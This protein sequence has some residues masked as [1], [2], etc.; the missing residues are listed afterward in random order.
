M[1]FPIFKAEDY[2][3][4]SLKGEVSFCYQVKT[5][6]LTQMDE[7]ESDHFYFQLENSLKALKENYFYRFFYLTGIFYLNTN[8][9]EVAFLDCELIQM[10]NP[11]NIL[12]GD[13]DIYQDITF[14]EDYFLLNSEFIRLLNLY[15]LP[16]IGHEN[17]FT[18]FGDYVLH[19][20]KIEPL[21]AK[22]T[23]NFRRKLHFSS[24]HE[25]LRNIES[26]NAYAQSEGLYQNIING[27]DA[28]FDGEGWII[29]RATTK[30]E[31][32]LKTKSLVNKAKLMDMRLLAE[33]DGM[34]FFFNSL[35]MGVK[36]TFKRKHPIPASTLKAFVP[37]KDERLM[38]EG[39]RLGSPSGSELNFSLFHP[40][41]TNFNLLLTGTSGQGKSMLAN[42]ILLEELRHERKI[43]VLDLGNSFKKNIAY[44]GG[45]H[46]SDKF[47][48]LQFKNPAYLK[49][50]IKSVVNDN[51]LS[52]RDEG[53]LFE[54]LK[55]NQFKSMKE[56]IEFLEVHFEGIR[57]YFSELMDF[58]TDETNEFHNLTYCDLSLYSERIKAPLIIYL[59]EY[60]KNLEGKKIF[61]FDECWGLLEGHADYIAE[62]FRT[63]RKHDASAIA[64]AQN[65]DDFAQ[66]P[67][68]QVI[69][70]N[71]YF[72]FY[73]RQDCDSEKYLGIREAN[74]V[75]SI[76]S[77]K[78]HY[79]EFLA[80]SDLFSKIVHYQ[81]SIFE[82]ELF[83]TEKKEILAFEQF[84]K[85]REVYMNFPDIFDQYFYLKHPYLMEN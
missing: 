24:L 78:N 11:L 26:E 35:I 30:D 10:S 65:L 32:D 55:E 79:S 51:F 82:F 5:P 64:I 52:L 80:T 72:K 46:F 85:P 15:E 81:S 17:I 20:R 14:Y 50:F 7:K 63:F 13:C 49:S 42:K 76:K 47:N 34:A 1:M 9:E 8:D 44:H 36:P 45:I 18:E 66:F 12:F 70:Q 3:L 57:F 67:L 56:F 69:I 25:S 71:C 6:D 27:Q 60:F 73:F 39:F 54:L 48:P 62:C 21:K 74:I 28:L 38:D 43:V 2:K 75:Q 40:V 53:K 41:A 84:S 19:V 23:L 61:L 83:N 29:V 33:S 4:T 31:L 68:G 58:F 77:K 22:K 59:I 16:G 37:I